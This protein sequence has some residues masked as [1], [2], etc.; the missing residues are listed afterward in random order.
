[1][2]KRQLQGM[3]AGTRAPGLRRLKARPR[4]YSNWI[5]ATVG[6]FG[7]LLFAFATMPL[8]LNQ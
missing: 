5:S 2:V 4:H 1:M 3:G 8:R 7:S 6:A